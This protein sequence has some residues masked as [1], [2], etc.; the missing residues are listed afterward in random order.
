MRVPKE[1]V[2]NDLFRQNPVITSLHLKSPVHV[3]PPLEEKRKSWSLIDWFQ[4]FQIRWL[5]DFPEES[6]SGSSACSENTTLPYSPSSSTSW[7]VYRR[8]K[9]K[10][11]ARWSK[12]RYG[13]ECKK[14]TK[15]YKEDK[16]K[17]RNETEHRIIREKKEELIMEDRARSLAS[18]VK[19][20][21]WFVTSLTRFLG[22]LSL[23]ASYLFRQKPD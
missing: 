4:N 19:G 7:L 5:I 13:K 12:K 17:N 15:N 18:L 23:S 3:V 1:P 21:N 6:W 8:G 9:I 16:R 11:K 2:C 10:E 14:R 22:D 20:Q